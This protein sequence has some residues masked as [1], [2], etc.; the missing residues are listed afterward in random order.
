MATDGKEESCPCGSGRAYQECC[1]SAD[2]LNAGRME[3]VSIVQTQDTE[4][5]TDFKDFRAMMVRKHLRAR[6]LLFD[7]P[8]Y[9]NIPRRNSFF[10]LIILP[11][12][13]NTPSPV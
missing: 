2:I 12:T 5:K 11:E 13:M 7:F 1:Y 9:H 8:F 6:S 10:R 3:D 4:G